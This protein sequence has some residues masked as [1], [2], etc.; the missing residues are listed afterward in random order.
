LTSHIPYDGPASDRWSCGILLFLILACD[1][2]FKPNLQ[3]DTKYNDMLRGHYPWPSSLEE[4]FPG[5]VDFLT[6]VLDPNP[7]TRLTFDQM[8]EHSWLRDAAVTFAA[9]HEIS[10][11][12]SAMSSMSVSSKQISYV[13]SKGIHATAI[14]VSDEGQ[15]AEMT[16]EPIPGEGPVY[17]GLARELSDA[18]TLLMLPSFDLTGS[19]THFETRLSTQ[20]VMSTLRDTLSHYSSSAKQPVDV[21]LSKAGWEARVVV[22]EAAPEQEEGVKGDGPLTTTV[23]LFKGQSPDARLVHFRRD[24]G[25]VMD[26]GDFYDVVSSAFVKPTP[27]PTV[28]A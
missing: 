19:A 7:T 13:D 5:S 1:Y 18:G 10:A 24:Q 12:T 20:E 22:G 23:Q 16:Y 14:D 27:T 9:A 8:R 4:H 2:P 25:D 17:R 28:S 11:T 21:Q 26:W 3:Q 15:I 6:K